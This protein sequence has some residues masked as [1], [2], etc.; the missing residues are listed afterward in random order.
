[1]ALVLIVGMWVV[2]GL[3]SLA[4]RQ[5]QRGSTS[6][7]GQFRRQLGV[8]GRT[9]PELLVAPANRLRVPRPSATV[10]TFPD[11]RRRQATGFSPPPVRPSTWGNTT[12]AHRRFVPRA[13]PSRI[14]GRPAPARSLPGGPARAASMRGLGRQRTIERRRNVLVALVS[15]TVGTA[16]IGAVPGARMM[17]ALAAIAA[18]ALAAYVG[19][20]VRIRNAA[21]ERE[22]KL[23]YLPPPRQVSPELMLRRS[24]TN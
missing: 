1:M 20:L 5:A 17:W 19:L 7:I 8:L 6:S 16:V 11:P 24:A 14:P 15:V 4:R 2:V 21:A 9:G 22:L 12:E 10:V 3:V 13:V 18:V 23:A